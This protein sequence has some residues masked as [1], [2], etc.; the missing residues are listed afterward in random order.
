[1]KG[2]IM[3]EANRSVD[4][5]R[6]RKLTRVAGRASART[7]AT[8]PDQLPEWTTEGWKHRVEA[9]ARRLLKREVRDVGSARR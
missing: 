2:V 7:N 3:G 1:M 5:V 4:I 6:R 8:K 9:E